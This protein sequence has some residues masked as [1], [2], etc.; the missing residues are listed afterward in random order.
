MPQFNYYP[1]RDVQVMDIPG[2]LREAQRLKSARTTN[3]LREFDLQQKQREEGRRQQF[4]G[5]LPEIASGNRGA[6]V[7]GLALDSEQTGQAMDVLGKMDAR[8]LETMKRQ[9]NTL[10]GL[11]ISVLTAPPVQRASMWPQARQMAIA[12]GA[13]PANVPELYD[14]G[15]EDK[16]RLWAGQAKQIDTLL[17]QMP[18]VPA[19]YRRAGGGLEF[20]PGGPADPTQA[21]RLAEA[22]RGGDAEPSIVQIAK[23]YREALTAEGKTISMADAL[24]WA[25]TSVGNT[26]E[27][28]YMKAYTANVRDFRTKEPAARRIAD[29]LTFKLHGVRFGEQPPDA[30]GRSSSLSPA[31]GA[32]AAV[33]SPARSPTAVS[34]PIP[35]SP[36]FATPRRK[37]TREIDSPK[38][39][40]PVTAQGKVNRKRLVVG[41]TYE[42]PDLTLWRWNGKRFTQVAE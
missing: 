31:G 30:P 23:A 38:R 39:P 24:R 32:R 12:A 19:G 37:P 2:V 28:T 42:A 20:T 22:K 6:V 11:A 33:P 35:S 17:G 29:D 7:R 13:N 21:G 40:I 18:D 16:L 36:E 27:Q 26:P 14:E 15:V 4:R 10:G 3:R 34:V 8:E 9:A 1:S 25:K 41:Q 5:L